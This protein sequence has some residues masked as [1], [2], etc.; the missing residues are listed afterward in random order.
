MWYM[1][2]NFGLQG[3][4]IVNNCVESSPI[5]Q[6]FAV[7]TERRNLLDTDKIKFFNGQLC[8]FDTIGLI[9]FSSLEN[10]ETKEGQRVNL[11]YISVFMCQNQK[12]LKMGQSQ[13]VSLKVKELGNLHR[14]LG[15]FG[16]YALFSYLAMNNCR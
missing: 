4:H 13:E 7:C 8:I 11:V 5:N 3:L 9:F 10:V 14:K 6:T 12:W 1:W 2:Q 15:L 16:Q